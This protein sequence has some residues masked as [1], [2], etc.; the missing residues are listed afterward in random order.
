MKNQAIG[1]LILKI[2]IILVA[3]AAVVATVFLCIKANSDNRQIRKDLTVEAGTTDFSANDFLRDKSL[4]ARF[5]AESQYNLNKVGTYS[6]QLVVG[7]ERF[8]VTL[9]VV[10]TVKPVAKSTPMLVPLGESMTPERLLTDIQDATAVTAEYEKAP[11]TTKKGEQEVSILLTDE[12]ENMLRV[13]TKIYVTETVNRVIYQ[14][15]EPYPALS[16]FIGENADA[17]FDP[18]LSELQITRP[19]TYYLGVSIFGA[20]YSVIMDAI[21]TILPVASAVQGFEMNPGVALPAPGELVTGVYDATELT[22]AYAD[23]YDFTEPGEYSVVVSVTDLGGNQTMVVVPVRVV[24]TGEKDTVPPVINGATDIV[25]NVGSIISYADN[26][27]VFD[28]YDGKL[29]I[30]DPARFAVDA[31][32]VR[33][34]IV[35]SYPVVYTAKDRAGNT[36]SVTVNVHIYHMEVNDTTIYAYAGSV[37]T[38]IVKDSMTREEKIESI[39]RYVYGLTEKFTTDVY[40][41]TSDRYTR[42]AYYGFLGYANDP[43]T[44]CSMLRVL[45]DTA[46]IEYKTVSRVS[47]DFGHWW[48]LVDFGDGWFHVDALQN[49]YVWTTDNRILR[50]DSNEAKEL[51]IGQIR[52]T[53]RMT[54]ADLTAYTA[55]VNNYR[56]GWNYY[57]F[58]TANYP[59]TPVRNPNGTYTPATYQLT[60]TAGNGGSISG[61]S[62]QMVAHGQSGSAVIAVAGYMYRFVRWDDGVTTPIRTDAVNDNKT[63]KAIFEFDPTAVTFYRLEYKAGEGGYLNGVTSQDLREG[64]TGTAVMAVATEGYRFVGWSDGKTETIRTD[65]A[66][67]N[68]TITAIFELIPVPEEPEIP[69]NPEEV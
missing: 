35:G 6:L 52:F 10:D 60:Y 5:S 14:L 32:A 37:L 28:A 53:Y 4:T 57:V 63:F 48:L 39:Y 44:A 33:P 11:D 67:S 59:R 58:A 43:F 7:D 13:V 51:D 34:N 69:E 40:S 62:V 26:I 45:L 49:G 15:G 21:D 16:D 68:M 30:R 54:D 64:S 24:E 1:N 36:S 25:T 29:D 56:L 23:T 22:Y 9:H 47:S 61:V 17:K 65:V 3:V 46:G 8:N 20:T 31:S 55:L 2:L 38:D 66:T 18:P 50:A 41:D 27:T 42:Q 19:D 12:G